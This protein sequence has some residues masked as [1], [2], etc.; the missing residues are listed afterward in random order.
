MLD[1]LHKKISNLF[2]SSVKAD[3]I[4]SILQKGKLKLGSVRQIVQGH[5]VSKWPCQDSKL[6]LHP[7][8][9]SVDVTMP[10]S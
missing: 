10:H 8:K 2:N 1:I 9:I 4:S 3:S 7:D 6:G 5:V